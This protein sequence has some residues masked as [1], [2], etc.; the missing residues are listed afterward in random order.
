MIQRIHKPQYVFVV[1]RNGSAPTNDIKTILCE[2][3]IKSK[4]GVITFYYPYKELLTAYK[5]KFYETDMWGVGFFLEALQKK[6]KFSD[7]RQLFALQDGG[8]TSISIQTTLLDF[9]KLDLKAGEAFFFAPSGK[10]SEQIWCNGIKTDET[11]KKQYKQW[12]CKGLRND[13]CGGKSDGE[14]AVFLEGIYRR[15][16]W[17]NY[18]EVD[19]NELFPVVKLFVSPQGGYSLLNLTP[20]ELHDVVK[21][22]SEVNFATLF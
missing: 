18:K 17:M 19:K 22:D 12:W 2:K 20:Q 15:F 9:S 16:G 14:I 8:L 11:T 1:L 4:D 5:T 3:S 13:V 6:A 21:K 7:G 10:Y